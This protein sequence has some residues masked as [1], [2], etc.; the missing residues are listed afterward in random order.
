MQQYLLANT[1][2]M[3]SYVSNSWQGSGSTTITFVAD[4]QFN[5]ASTIQINSGVTAASGALGTVD[6][7]YGIPTVDRL[8]IGQSRSSDNTNGTL[9]RLTY[10]PQRL[11]NETLQT[12]TQ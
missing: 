4:Q 2:A 9:R 5:V 6:T 1:A 7:S 3:D 10:W 12:I 11:P 8:L